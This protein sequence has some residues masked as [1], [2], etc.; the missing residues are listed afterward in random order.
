VIR[1]SKKV[2]LNISILHMSTLL[3]QL[4]VQYSMHHLRLLHIVQCD[5]VIPALHHLIL[6]CI[7]V[8]CL[9]G[10]D[11]R[12]KDRLGAGNVVTMCD[13]GCVL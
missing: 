2:H 13:R 12:L 4:V 5:D 6:L 1:V 3:L 9:F 7:N 8:A 10:C 11:R